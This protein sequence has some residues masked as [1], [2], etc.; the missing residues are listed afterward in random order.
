[1][2][3]PGDSPAPGPLGSPSK[4]TTTS[5]STSPEDAPREFLREK[6]GRQRLTLESNPTDQASRE[7][8]PHGVVEGQHRACE[9]PLEDYP[10]GPDV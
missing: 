10:G 1:M 7:E 3:L 2:P 6:T 8:S 4:G 9:V 5:P